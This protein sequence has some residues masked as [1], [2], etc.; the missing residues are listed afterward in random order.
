MD[1]YNFKDVK[2]L[3]LQN[4]SDHLEF[5]KS[6]SELDSMGKALCGFL[7]NKD[8]IGLIGI[9]DHKKIIGVD[10]TDSVDKKL[11]AFL[12]KFEPQGRISVD[13]VRIP[14]SPTR[15]NI[16]VFS[17]DPLAY[18]KPYSFEGRYYQRIQSTSSLM[19]KNQ[20]EN[21]LLENMQ[22]I[23]NWETLPAQ[24]FDVDILDIDSIN[25]M[26]N[27]GIEASRIPRLA[28]NQTI[29]ENLMRL[30]LLTNNEQLTN[31]ALV[32]FGNNLEQHYPQCTIKLARFKGTDKLH[33]FIDNR[34]FYNNAFKIIDIAESFMCQYLPI[35]GS[36]DKDKFQRIDRLIIPNLALREALVN[37]ICHRNYTNKNGEITLAIYNDRLE[38]WN[39]GTLPNNLTL[40][41]LKKKHA[42][43]PRNKLISELFYKCGLVEHWGSGTLRMLELCK[44]AKLPEPIYEEY[45][46]GFSITFKFKAPL[47]SG[48][49]II[50]DYKHLTGRQKAILEVFINTD[51]S[52]SF[53][54]IASLIDSSP[55]R[56][57]LQDELVRLKKLHLIDYRGRGRGAKWYFLR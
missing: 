56:R 48:S 1:K 14:T 17:A 18:E 34:L 37:A 8:G 28:K 15:K 7:N 30:N 11:A 53:N 49:L 45:S 40:E 12:K 29:K 4:E 50:D 36:F 23:N 6:T 33:G 26:I 52:L 39:L 16:I 3:I 24:K 55:P 42:S 22:H 2:K 51:E 35:S 44:E 47:D 46:N 19:P 27:M 9:T 57:T 25:Q 5:K 10:V 43:F 21:R 38:I 20:V 13:Y 41:D 32:L 54:E 31:A